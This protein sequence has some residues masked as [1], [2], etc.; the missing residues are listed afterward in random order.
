VFDTSAQRTILGRVTDLRR[1]LAVPVVAL[2]LLAGAC[3]GDDDDS[4]APEPTN[5]SGAPTLKQQPA[6]LD[7]KIARVSG[8]LPTADA[9]AVSKRLGN[10]VATWFNGGFLSGDYPRS[11]F[12]GYDAAFTPGAAKLAQRDSGVTTNAQLGSQWVEVVPTRQVVRL[13]VF[14]PGHRVSGATARVELVMV[15]ADEGGSASEL[16]VTGEL[17]L[18]K[19]KAG[20]RIF[21]FDLQ[22]AV[23]APGA[24][25]AHLRAQRDQQQK[26][27]SNK[28]DKSKGQGN[29]K[30]DKGSSRGKG[31]A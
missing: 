18:T 8:A 28:P 30:H 1:R 4:S 11:S 29:G 15:G 6:N 24:Y 16:A 21:G 14:A 5:Q 12:S 23:G 19:T 22:R 31:R 25:V 13:Y 26:D 10:V 7:V 20:W 3:S 27:P 9:K 17:Y 2:A